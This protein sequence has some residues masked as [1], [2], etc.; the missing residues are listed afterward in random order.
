MAV[1]SRT[2]AL[3]VL[4]GWSWWVEG[5][6]RPRRARD[7]EVDS[8]HPDNARRRYRS[9]RR[10]LQPDGDHGVYSFE[11]Q[12]RSAGLVL[13]RKTYEGLA[14]YWPSQSGRWADMV[15]PLPKYVGSRTLSGDLAWN[16]TLLD[17][18]LEDSIP[19]LKAR[20]DGD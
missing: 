6:P 9:S 10:V 2:G 15:N 4:R 1:G 18:E 17:G 16:A 8:H 13:G 20:V 3:P 7:G 14:G 11:R 19:R 12:A 5:R